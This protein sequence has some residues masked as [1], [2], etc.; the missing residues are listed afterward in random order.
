[1]VYRLL[2]GLQT[3]DEL[4]EASSGAGKRKS[5]TAHWCMSLGCFGGTVCLCPVPLLCRIAGLVLLL[6]PRPR[7]AI[8]RS[9]RS[10]P[11]CLLLF[12]WLF[13]PPA[14]LRGGLHSLHTADLS[15]AGWLVFMYNLGLVPLFAGTCQLQQRCSAVPSSL[16]SLLVPPQL[17]RLPARQRRRTKRA[18][19]TVTPNACGTPRHQRAATA[20]MP[21]GS[22]K[23]P[24]SATASTSLVTGRTKSTAR[25]PSRIG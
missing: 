22:R 4:N 10:K 8:V 13:P 12:P 11:L 23:L 5:V 14:P 24:E 1:M 19:V 17:R 18:G 7:P 20:P 16:L 15:E 25:T 21:A 9:V 3:L 2:N 6:R